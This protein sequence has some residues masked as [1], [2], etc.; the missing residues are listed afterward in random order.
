MASVATHGG[1]WATD[2]AE[3]MVRR[4]TPFRVAHEEA[5]ALVRRHEAGEDLGDEAFG[6][7]RSEPL[8]ALGRRSSH[9]STSPPRVRE[10]VARLRA[11]LENFSD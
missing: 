1:S 2:V 3:E 7:E 6:F 10:Q 9:G 8:A 5:G 11:A 4:G